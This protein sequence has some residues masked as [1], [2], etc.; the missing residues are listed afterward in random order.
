MK[1]LPLMLKS[2][3]RKKTRT[4]LTMASILLPLLV[5]CVLGTMLDV[6]EN[7]DPSGGRGMYRIIVRHKVSL[8]FFIPD[9]YRNRIQALD[10]VLGI[11]AFSWFGGTYIDDSAD[12]QFARF[13]CDPA[14]FLAIYDEAEIIEGSA[15][16]WI[17]DK[18]GMLAGES[19]CKKYGW[20]LGDKITLKGDIFPVNVEL[21]LRAI[22][23]AEEA[24]TVYFHRSMVEEA[25]PGMKG[26][27]GTLWLKTDSPESVSRLCREIDALFENSDAPVKAESEKEFQ[28]SFISMLGNVKFM[29]SSICIAITAVILLIAANTMAMSARERITEV[30]VLRTLGF[31]KPTI[32]SLLLG[33]SLLLSLIGGG[34]G[35]LLFSVALPVMKEWLKTTPGAGFAAGMR[36]A[37]PVL[38]TAFLITV[39]VGF[40]A[41]L[42][43]AIQAARRPITQGLRQVA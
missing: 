31:Q 19:L 11:S 13:T 15:A 25:L 5:I 42:V 32:L 22:Y 9:A 33:E 28:N 38:W 4:L 20:K 18:S 2:L 39:A 37:P 8:S 24:S 43:P 16:D 36:L 14:A 29:V 41:G 3:L 1:F 30:A 27:V 26:R 35:L 6:L 10:G 23:R 12:N 34:L 40:L 21:T 17:A 7:G